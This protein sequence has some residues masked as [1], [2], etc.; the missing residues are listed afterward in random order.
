MSAHPET[1][2]ETP[3]DRSVCPKRGDLGQLDRSAIAELIQRERSARDAG[4]WD[5]M[6]A[7]FH[8]DAMI[9]VSWF[10]GGAVDF[11]AATKRV[12]EAGRTLSLHRLSPSVVTLNED[13][14]LA[15][16]DAEMLGFSTL[17]GVDVCGVHQVRLLWRAQVL[18][19]RWLIAGLHCVYVRGLLLPCNPAKPPVIDEALLAT[20]RPSYRYLSYVLTKNG[21][22][23]RDDLP[24]VDR[25]ESVTALRAAEAAW[26]GE[27]R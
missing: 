8:P 6:A 27:A 18:D 7:C 26:L 25:P 5:V 23:A 24:G 22:P 16:T 11:V 19:E 13:R 2:S 10:K 15:E 20:Y 12:A 17:D 14:A 4:R 21:M 3:V 1:P 9:D